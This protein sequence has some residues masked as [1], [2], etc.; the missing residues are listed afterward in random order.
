MC[1]VGDELVA[2]MP[3]RELAARILLHEQR[4]LPVLAPRLPLPIPAP[5][6]AA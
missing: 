4:W 2:R 1:R 5:T 3:R 6:R